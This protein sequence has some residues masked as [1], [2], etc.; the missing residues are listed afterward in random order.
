MAVPGDVVLRDYADAF[1]DAPQNLAGIR[2]RM[3]QELGAA[4]VVEAAALVGI[5]DAVVRVADSTGI[6]IEEYKVEPTKEMRQNLG[7]NDFH[8]AGESGG[9]S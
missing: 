1:Y 3:E 4:A 2:D 9:A 8:S 7:I 6:P 5:Y